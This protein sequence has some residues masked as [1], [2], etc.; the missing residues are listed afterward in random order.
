MQLR[1][2]WSRAHSGPA[3][4]AKANPSCL[5]IVIRDRTGDATAVCVFMC[6]GGHCGRQQSRIV[7]TAGAQPY[8]TCRGAR[9][10]GLSGLLCQRAGSVAGGLAWLAGCV[11]GV[12]MGV[13]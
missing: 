7:D 9:E 4:A 11:C 6:D 8:A 3:Q 1:L 13:L 12:I 10:L 5:S 2:L